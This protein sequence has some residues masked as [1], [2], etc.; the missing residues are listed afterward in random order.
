[1]AAPELTITFEHA[2]ETE[3][4]ARGVDLS[5]SSERFVPP[6]MKNENIRICAVQLFLLTP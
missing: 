4:R 2:F 6:C 3:L 5:G 1:M